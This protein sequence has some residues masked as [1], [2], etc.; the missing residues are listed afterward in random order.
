MASAAGFSTR[1]L[2]LQ[3]RDALADRIARREWQPGSTLPNEVELSRQLEVSQGTVR[4]ALSELEIEHLVTRRQGRGTF[5][6]DLTTSEQARRFSN[7]RGPDNQRVTGSISQI[8]TKLAAANEQERARLR[9][10]PQEQVIR[11]RRIRCADQKPFMLEDVAMPAARFPGLERQP[12]VPQMMSALAQHFGL[13]L[14]AAQERISIAPATREIADALSIEPDTAL[15]HLDRVIH[16]MEGP[17]IQWRV[18]HCHLE[19]GHH[20]LV[21]MGV[22]GR[23]RKF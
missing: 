17:P 7:L 14:G 11:I 3:V 10:R 23:K 1:P 18:A 13:L 19:G 12:H 2:Y 16:L 21:E 5:V 6:N 9:L 15:L 22:N 20:Y 4:K 8:Q